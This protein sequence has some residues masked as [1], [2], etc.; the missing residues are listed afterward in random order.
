[1]HYL[2]YS[3]YLDNLDY[4]DYVDYLDY[5]LFLGLNYVSW[6]SPQ[7]GRLVCTMQINNIYERCSHFQVL[8]GIPITSILGRLAPVPVGDTAR[9]PAPFLEQPAIQSPMG[10][11]STLLPWSWQ[12]VNKKNGIAASLARRHDFT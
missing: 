6:N 7:A 5:L 3:L 11:M 2:I 1:M 12:P 10:G 8:Y 4:L 9:R